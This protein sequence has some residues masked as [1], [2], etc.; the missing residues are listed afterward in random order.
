M[1]TDDLESGV[2]H[3]GAAAAVAVARGTAVA[4]ARDSTV[5]SRGNTT[6]ELVARALTA[7][8]LYHTL[9]ASGYAC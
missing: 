3:E 7:V 8:S 4:V 5:A 9:A 6:L 1:A 2:T